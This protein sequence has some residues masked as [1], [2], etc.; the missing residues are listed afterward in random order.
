MEIQRVIDILDA[1]RGYVADINIDAIIAYKEA[2]RALEKQMSKKPTVSNFND[3]MRM[4][5]VQ[6]VSCPICDDAIAMI[7]FKS[8]KEKVF[9]NN[10]EYKHCCKCGQK[11]DW[12]LDV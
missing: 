2:I 3:L 12:S 6:R 9:K 8:E 10:E 7:E 5:T 1:R 4:R 11:L